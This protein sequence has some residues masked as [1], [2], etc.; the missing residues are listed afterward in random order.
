MKH[1]R[2]NLGDRKQK[3]GIPSFGMEAAT[4]LRHPTQDGSYRRMLRRRDTVTEP[5]ERE[6]RR[7][8]V[9]IIIW[10]SYL[11]L[12]VTETRRGGK[13]KGAKHSREAEGGDDARRGRKMEIGTIRR[14]L[15]RC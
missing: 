6:D 8:I 2:S 1:S 15:H 4:S 5:R 9:F 13:G 7:G 10:E 14:H 3:T 12:S 11:L